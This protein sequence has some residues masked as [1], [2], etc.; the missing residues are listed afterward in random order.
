[1]LNSLRWAG[2]PKKCSVGLVEVWYLGLHL[3]HGH[4]CPKIDKTAAIVASPKCKTKK[5]VRQMLPGYWQISLKKGGC[6]CKWNF[7]QI[8]AVRVRAWCCILMTCLSYS[9]VLKTDASDRGLGPF[10]PR[11]GG[12]PST[13]HWLE[14]LIKVQQVQLIQK[15]CLAIKWEVLTLL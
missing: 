8:K 7:S 4:V 9:F 12:M 3:G 11:C 14:A 15:I 13:V 10:S 2:L 1:M 6:Q 5:G